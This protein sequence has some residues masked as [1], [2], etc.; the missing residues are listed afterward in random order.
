MKRDGFPSRVGEILE[1]TFEKLGIAKKMKEQRILKLW[2]KAVGERI[3][4]HTHPFLIRKGVL[5]VRVDSS[6]WLAQLNYLKEDIIYKLNR[7]EEGVI[8]DIY[9]RLGARENDT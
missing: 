3:S 9:F 7:E 6:V 1:R 4:Q 2:R 8:R 5:F